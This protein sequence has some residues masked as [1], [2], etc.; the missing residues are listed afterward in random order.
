MLTVCA[1]KTGCTCAPHSLIL[2]SPVDTI[3][4]VVLSL[5]LILHSLAPCTPSTLSA[6][7]NT[8]SPEKTF[9]LKPHRNFSHVVFPSQGNR[10]SSEN[11][12]L[13]S[14]NNSKLSLD[15]STAGF[16]PESA[17]NHSLSYWCF[18]GERHAQHS[19]KETDPRGLPIT[20]GPGQLH[21]HCSKALSQ[22][23]QLAD[24][25]LPLRKHQVK[26]KEQLSC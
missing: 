12:T 18:C 15:F 16:D 2:I 14:Q 4:M 9:P 19:P 21:T 22:H 3:W 11:K 26:G 6:S 23:P 8:L 5:L 10:H 25:T 17:Q 13:N 20:L 24:V 7:G 1:R